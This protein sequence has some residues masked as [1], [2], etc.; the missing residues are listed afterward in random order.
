MS[1][2]DFD[3]ETTSDSEGKILIEDEFEEEL[4]YSSTTVKIV[5]K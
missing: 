4:Q 5:E 2:Y 1:N 3:F